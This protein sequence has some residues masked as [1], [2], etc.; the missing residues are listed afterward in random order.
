MGTAVA[1]E[2]QRAPG[3]EEEREEEWAEA[4][5]LAL[6]P[7]ADF[8]E[9]RDH[10]GGAPGSD[11]VNPAFDPRHSSLSPDAS[12]WLAARDRDGRIA[13]CIAYRTF[14][15]SDVRELIRTM[16]IFCEGSCDQ[17]SGTLDLVLPGEMPRIAG[18]LGFPGGLWVRAD[19][20]GNGLSEHMLR[21]V[22]KEALARYPLDWEVAVS[23]KKITDSPSLRSLYDFEHVVPCFDGFFPL[24]RRVE[25]MALQYSS[26][27]HLVRSVTGRRAP[28]GGG[29]AG[30]SRWGNPPS[31]VG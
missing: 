6:T 11:G 16:R 2:E 23:F 1:R 25:R 5:G 27:G 12:F 19:F 17:H 30:G 8:A 15:T 13:A 10:L 20:R 31:H 24:T 28:G 21:A 14:R 29:T 7:Q 22:R 26:R 3:R 9:F 4:L 18:L